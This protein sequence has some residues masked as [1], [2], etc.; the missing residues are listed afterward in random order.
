MEIFKDT[1]FKGNYNGSERVFTIKQIFYSW[2]G[3]GKFCA[4]EYDLLQTGEQ[5]P[6]RVTREKLI[7]WIND[8]ILVRTWN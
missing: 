3:A 5:E 7:N 2:D 1:Q 8:K 4:V 6:K